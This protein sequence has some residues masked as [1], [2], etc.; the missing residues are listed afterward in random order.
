M[1][2]NARESK[3]DLWGR[4]RR[5]NCISAIRAQGIAMA[6]RKQVGSSATSEREAR[7]DLDAPRIKCGCEAK[8][9]TGSI[10]VVA[11]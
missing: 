6:A 2:S 8:R 1:R 4:K 10:A 9:L 3:S 5:T 11:A 7:A